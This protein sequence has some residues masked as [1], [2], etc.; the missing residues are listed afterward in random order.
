MINFVRG[1]NRLACIAGT[2]FILISVVQLAAVSSYIT[3]DVVGTPPTAEE[4]AA[5]TLESLQLEISKQSEMQRQNNFISKETI[6]ARWDDNVW[7]FDT[8][9]HEKH[10]SMC[11]DVNNDAWLYVAAEMWSIEE[12]PMDIIIKRSTDHGEE[13][14]LNDG[15]NQYTIHASPAVNPNFSPQLVQ[16]TPDKIGLVYINEHTTGSDWDILFHTLSTH[17]LSVV[18]PAFVDFTPAILKRPS[19]CSDFLQYGN[20]AYIHVAYINASASPREIKYARSVDQGNT[21]QEAEVV[22]TISDEVEGEFHYTSIDVF[23]SRVAIAYV[24][25]E[26]DFDAI[27]VIISN[28]SGEN[29]NDPVT[30]AT[31][32]NF[33]FPQIRV[34]NN[35]NIIVT[36]EYWYSDSDIDVY[37]AYSHDGGGSFSAHQMLAHSIENERFPNVSSHKTQNSGSDVYIT[38]TM[39]PDEIYVQKALDLDYES[40]SEAVAVKDSDQEVSDNHVTSI[41]VKPYNDVPKC[42]VA[43][44]EYWTIIDADIRFD[45]EWRGEVSVDNPDIVDSGTLL[46]GNYPNPFNPETTIEFFLNEPGEVT[47]DIYNIKGQLVRSLVN[48]SYQAGTHRIIWDGKS[49]NGRE[50]VSGVYFS[51]METGDYSGVRKMIMMK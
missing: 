42:A 38:Y 33:R 20:D 29:W 3:Q 27:K 37:Y 19:V 36:F 34:V 18:Q 11:Y 26:E 49:D 43:W 40:W 31:T 51:R 28:D 14:P 7:V 10:P 16:T 4:I 23:G 22:A 48:N 32:R 39:L 46:R 17:N 2:F 45:A 44:T 21:F 24:D 35:Q 50:V 30:I 1:K 6:P 12:E 47:I 13:W 8:G 15:E 25:R 5:K 9:S 41:I